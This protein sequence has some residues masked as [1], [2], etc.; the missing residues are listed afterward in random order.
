MN[1]Y[2]QA[3]KWRSSHLPVTNMVQPATDF[4]SAQTQVMVAGTKR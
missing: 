2:S 1:T 4:S 3:L